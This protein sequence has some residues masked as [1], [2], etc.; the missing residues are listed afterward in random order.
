MIMLAAR[1]TAL[2]GS[3]ASGRR[4]GTEGHQL[5]SV[6]IHRLRESIMVKKGWA[7]LSFKLRRTCAVQKLEHYQPIIGGKA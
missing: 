4:R 5:G 1:P 6:Y 7:P 2:M 3:I